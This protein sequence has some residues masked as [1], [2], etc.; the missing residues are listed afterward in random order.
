MDSGAF[1]LR[2]A[3]GWRSIEPYMTQRCSVGNAT[4]TLEKPLPHVMWRPRITGKLG[5]LWRIPRFYLKYFLSEFACLLHQRLVLER[6]CNVAWT[7]EYVPKTRQLTFILTQITKFWC[8][9][10][11]YQCFLVCLLYQRLVLELV[12]NVTWTDEN[13][14]KILRQRFRLI[15][16]IFLTLLLV[17]NQC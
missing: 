1:Q 10:L 9:W 6:V 2:K 4:K 5:F 15:M 7:D 3:W 11:L 16:T 12:C 14:S 13:I 8:C 17:L